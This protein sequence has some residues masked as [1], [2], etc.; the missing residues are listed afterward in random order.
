MDGYRICFSEDE[1][2]VIY[3]ELDRPCI[4]LKIMLLMK[5]LFSE[6]RFHDT[7]V[8]RPSGSLV[9][10]YDVG[11]SLGKGGYATVFSVIHRSTRKVYAAK[12]I[13]R[14]SEAPSFEVAC[15]KKLRHPNICQL[16][17]VFFQRDNSMSMLHFL[18]TGTPCSQILG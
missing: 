11:M 4:M 6:Y 17:E 5:T 10:H 3:S 13:T 14:F 12:K 2:S 1:D 7:T 18:Q 9:T 8:P 16:K 15:M